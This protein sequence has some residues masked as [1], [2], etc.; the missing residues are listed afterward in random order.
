MNKAGAT[1]FY[2]FFA[3]LPFL[4]VDDVKGY[5]LPLMKKLK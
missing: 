5:T 4:N 1:N 3:L 2:S